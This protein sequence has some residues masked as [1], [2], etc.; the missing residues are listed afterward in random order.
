MEDKKR[1]ALAK[2][3]RKLRADLGLMQ[4]EFAAKIGAKQ[5]LVSKWERGEHS[6]SAEYA[7][8]MAEL[9]GVPL[10]SFLGVQP[11]RK[12]EVTGHTVTVVGELQA[13]VW[14]EAVEWDFEEQFE[15]PYYPAPNVPNMPVRA[16][17]VRGTSMNRLYPDGTMVF[18]A[19][20][21]ANKLKPV[22]GNK[23][24]VSRRNADGFYEA[25]IKELVVD[26]NKRKW[27]WPRSYDP[28]H[29]APIEYAGGRGDEV[30]ITGVVVQASIGQI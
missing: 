6:P 14:R 21:I 20:T 12:A 19:S 5:D 16:F 23:V 9:A 27:L 1:D 30:T 24:L 7:S 15:V 13:G 18:V 28:E 25:T 17:I 11:L 10:G 29:Q 26:E 2:K 4:T 8:K 22:S 3:I